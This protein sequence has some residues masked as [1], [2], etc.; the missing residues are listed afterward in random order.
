[1]LI[2][3]DKNGV[4]YQVRYNAIGTPTWVEIPAPSAP[5]KFTNLVSFNARIKVVP[6]VITDQIYALDPNDKGRINMTNPLA[7]T[8]N[9]FTPVIADMTD[10]EFGIVDKARTADVNGITVTAPPGVTLNGVDGGSE[11]LSSIGGII[12]VHVDAPYAWST[13]GQ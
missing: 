12:I 6:Q 10:L 11:T 2:A 13:I 4:Y 3:V 8:V 5:T 7:R 1:M 9:L